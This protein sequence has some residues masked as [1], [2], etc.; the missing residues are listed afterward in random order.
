MFSRVLVLVCG[1]KSCSNPTLGSECELVS[2]KSL[3]PRTVVGV[4]SRFGCG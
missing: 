2:S 1:L 4:A 3:D